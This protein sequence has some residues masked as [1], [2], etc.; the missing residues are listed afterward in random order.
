MVIY[1]RGA[2]LAGRSPGPYLVAYRGR[3][4][5]KNSSERLRN[6]HWDSEVLASRLLNQTCFQVVV[7]KT[8][9]VSDGQLTEQNSEQLTRHLV[10]SSVSKE[11]RLA[12]WFERRTASFLARN[13]TSGSKQSPCFET[14]LCITGLLKR[15][16][17][18][19]SIFQQTNGDT[20]SASILS[21]RRSFIST[22]LSVISILALA[23]TERSLGR[24]MFQL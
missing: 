6:I 20:E 12:F 8:G 2:L 23:W 5:S 18:E 7:P 22:G 15:H 14:N 17:S 13:Q 9:G 3:Y 10:Y 4:S 19:F 1:Y 11:G 16:Q 21:F 24:S